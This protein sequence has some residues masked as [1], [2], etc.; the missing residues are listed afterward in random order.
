MNRSQ[1]HLTFENPEVLILTHN[2]QTLYTSS[3][4]IEC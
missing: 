3:I 2:F 4:T 1:L